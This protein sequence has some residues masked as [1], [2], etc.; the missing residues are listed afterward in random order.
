MP[1][2]TPRSAIDQDRLLVTAFRSPVTGAPSRSLHPRVNVPGLLL[3]NQPHVSTA[4]SD[5]RSA[6]A[7]GSPRSAATSSRQSRCSASARLDWLLPRSP[8]PFGTFTSLRIE[9]FNRIGHHSVRLP[10]PP[11]FQSLPEASSISRFD[12][13][14]S[15]LIRY[16]SGG[17][18]F[19]KP[20]GTSFTMR[21]KLS[22]VNTVC[23]RKTGFSTIFSILCF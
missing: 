3:R 23:A 19:L 1:S 12:F 7:T 11:D 10:N 18:L 2:G 15:F 5:F 9:A 17:L 8:L 4:R 13:G 22:S 16:V 20:L 21:S 6:T 14:S